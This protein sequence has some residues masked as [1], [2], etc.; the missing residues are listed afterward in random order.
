MSPELF[1]GLCTK[2]L[3]KGSHG[4]IE[5]LTIYCYGT[6]S[7]VIGG[8]VTSIPVLRFLEKMYSCVSNDETPLNNVIGL[9]M[10]DMHQAQ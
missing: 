10:K 9:T 1:D 5:H 7:I 8:A 2:S 6:S 3:S 4:I